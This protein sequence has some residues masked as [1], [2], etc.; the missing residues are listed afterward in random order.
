[1]PIYAFRCDVCDEVTDVFASVHD[2]PERVECGRCG[3]ADTHR[4]IS[5]VAYHASE[6]T[7]T[8]KLDPKYDRM[9][10]HAMKKSASADENR[11]LRRLK[12]FSS[13]SGK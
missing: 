13:D 4:I 7:K 5:R 6:A 8:A 10:D 3:S 1:M 2:I 12:P 9:V 11:L